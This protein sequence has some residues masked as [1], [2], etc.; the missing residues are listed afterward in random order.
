VPLFSQ[1]GQLAFHAPAAGTHVLTLEY[2]RY[3][4]LSLAAIAAFL[5][6]MAAINSCSTTFQGV[7][8]PSGLRRLCIR[9]AVRFT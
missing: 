6:G 7:A 3:R 4:W 5:F 2:P 1:D 9:I 8:R